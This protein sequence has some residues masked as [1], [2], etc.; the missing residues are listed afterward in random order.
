MATQD[1][2]LTADEFWE[3]YAGQRV[4]LVEGVP[5]EM[6]PTSDLHGEI[7]GLITFYLIGYVLEHDLGSVRSAET[8]FLISRDPDA[9]RA[10][11]VAFISKERGAQITDRD[12]YTPFPPDLAVE[13][14][15][16]SDR[17]G[18][19]QEKIRDYLEVGVRLLWVIHPQTQQVVVYTATSQT[20]L[21]MGD[22]L[23]GG[24]VLPGFALPLAK[25]FPTD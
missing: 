1:K 20:T 2:L 18:S 14:V 8:G 4:E 23:T 12:K 22:T 11:D 3:R 6:A 9:V 25:L 24:E 19:I 21:S 5:V 10:A 15:S 7:A 16:P 13:V 17:A